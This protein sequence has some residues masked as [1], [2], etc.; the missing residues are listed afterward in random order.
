MQ[1][2]KKH[3]ILFLLDTDKGQLQKA[4][5]D[6]CNNYIT[7]GHEVHVIY[8]SSNISEDFEISLRKIP[9]I[10]AHK[11][12][13]ENNFSRRQFSMPF[14]IRKYIARHDGVDIIH[15]FG[16]N[17]GILS[18]FSSI[19]QKVKI[20]NTPDQINVNNDNKTVKELLKQF[21]KDNITYFFNNLCGNLVF[22]SEAEKNKAAVHVS[23][24]NV[25]S[26]L[27]N[28]TDNSAELSDR[29]MQIYE[30]ILFIPDK[31]SEQITT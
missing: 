26:E 17:C 27:I 14:A 16:L 29:L 13:I 30:N 9:W 1:E 5:P 4:L 31:I 8:P 2:E 20:I 3:S 15:S 12:P 23:Y 21:A 7:A 28:I 11:L 10:H 22:F 25:K 19:G 6:I 18:Y 24:K